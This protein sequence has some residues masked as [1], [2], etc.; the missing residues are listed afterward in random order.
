MGLF[1]VCRVILHICSWLQSLSLNVQKWGWGILRIRYIDSICSEQ[2]CI[3]SK[4]IICVG[5][6]KGNPGSTCDMSCF[7]PHKSAVLTKR[8]W[9][10]QIGN[11]L[12][13]SLKML[14]KTAELQT[15]IDFKCSNQFIF[16]KV[17]TLHFRLSKSL[18]KPKLQISTR[19]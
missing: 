13:R 8:I 11:I 9:Y 19:H 18:I 3:I 10:C 17:C 5:V 4:I 16:K 12:L 2:G 6:A 15:L 1:Q 14:D 7:S